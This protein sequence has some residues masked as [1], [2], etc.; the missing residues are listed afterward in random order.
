MEIFY[1]YFSRLTGFR[2]KVLFLMKFLKNCRIVYLSL[3]MI[4][5]CSINEEIYL[6]NEQ[7]NTDF[8]PEIFDGSLKFSDSDQFE[9]FMQNNLEKSVEDF[10]EQ[11][12]ALK[13]FNSLLNRDKSDNSFFRQSGSDDGD[14]EDE[15]ELVYDP[16]FASI[17]NEKRELMIEDMVFRITDHGVFSYKPEYR[18]KAEDFFGNL[19][20]LMIELP[21]GGDEPIM[22]VAEDVYYLQPTNCDGGG[23]YSP[24]SSP[25][26]YNDGCFTTIYLDPTIC[27]GNSSNIFGTTETCSKNTDTHRRLKVKFWNQDFQIYASF[28]V[29][30]RYQGRALG[31]WFARN[32][33]FLTLRYKIELKL[34][35][36]LDNYH[37][38]I[39]ETENPIERNNTNKI[40]RV[41]DWQAGTV[42]V[43]CYYGGGFGGCNPGDLKWTKGYTVPSFEICSY[44]KDGN[45]QASVRL[46][47]L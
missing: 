9:N 1:T 15:D 18:N 20:N 39:I 29:S 21:C 35:D 31:I 6:D 30:T 5:S 16:Y 7:L 42:K 26:V 47:G 19:L 12:F 36:F 11:I 34:K 3:I 8:L 23:G 10:Q 43:K 38:G 44:V 17:L 14:E 46:V 2:N 32:A 40:K 13:G 24:P 4:I 41:L 25:P 28:G 27:V 37:E 45:R 22:L 33:D